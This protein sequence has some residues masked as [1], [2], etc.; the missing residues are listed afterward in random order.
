MSFTSPI[1]T[2][3]LFSHLY[4]LLSDD[5]HLCN[6]WSPQDDAHV[7]GTVPAAQF[8]VSHISPFLAVGRRYQSTLCSGAGAQLVPHSMAMRGEVRLLLP[9]GDGLLREVLKTTAAAAVKSPR[10][11]HLQSPGGLAGCS[12]GTSQS[13]YCPKPIHPTAG[14]SLSRRYPCRE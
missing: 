5:V 11:A 14:H 9:I 2:F 8:P 10:L 4:P 3:L 1:I 13:S 6:G 12:G 7:L